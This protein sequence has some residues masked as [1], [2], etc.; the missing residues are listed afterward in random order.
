MRERRKEEGGVAEY[1]SR[2]LRFSPL[3]FLLAAPLAAQVSRDWRPEDRVVIG[4]WSRINAVATSPERVFASSP[5]GLLVWSPLF[6]RWEGPFDPPVPGMLETVFI[7]LID[8]LDNSVWLARPD[9]WV[10]YQ[11]DIRIWE[12][13]T[14]PGRV[15]EIAF[16][17]AAPTEGLFL[18]TTAGWF[19]VPR[20]A[21]SG[22]P[23]RPPQRPVRP[24]T[25]EQALAANPALRMTASQFLLD[26]A[27][28][29]AQLT[30]AARSFDNLGWYLGTS[31]VGLLFIQDGAAVPEKLTFGLPGAIA[32]AVVAV[33]GGVWVATDREQSRPAA[34]TFVAED[35]SEFRV[36]TG[37]PATGLRFTQ[38]RRLT[39]LGDVIWAATDN[40]VM[41]LPLRE[42]GD[43]L[44]LGES[45]GLPDRRALAISSRRGVLVAGTL[46]GLARVVDSVRLERIAPLFSDAAMAVA[47]QEDTIWVATPSGPLAAVPGQEN[48]VRPSGLEESAA[49]RQPVFD[50]AWSGDTLVALAADQFLWKDPASARWTVGVPFSQLLGRLRRL[51]PEG[52]GFWVAGE[53]GVAFT[54][55]GQAAER[56]L[57]VDGDLPGEPYDLAVQSDYLWVATSKGLVRFRLREIRP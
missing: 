33:P 54:R 2:M 53:R 39:A 8:P 17:L 45:D 10:H 56:P 32:G 47:F 9:G 29:P 35:L 6:R 38:V 27:L 1:L 12:R 34:L 13:G 4:D 20:G 15:Q 26:P 18:R 37:P 30:S 40:G 41:R 46:H 51:V 49:L 3:L 52:D 14:V 24:G 28:R 55:L 50:L 11:P 22:Q 42:G 16:D 36:V 25:V 21:I 44:M 57:L 43:P 31:G 23:G 19:I 5:T 48:L 7:G